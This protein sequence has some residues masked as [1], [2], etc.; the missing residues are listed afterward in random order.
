M[1]VRYAS[2]SCNNHISHD[3]VPYEMS[4]SS[5]GRRL[6]MSSK[7]GEKKYKFTTSEYNL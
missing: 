3:Y 7:N 4:A 5:A 6:N 2:I 1:C